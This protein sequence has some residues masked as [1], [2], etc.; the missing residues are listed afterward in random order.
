[1][2]KKLFFALIVLMALPLA[3][4]AGGQGGTPHR[5]RSPSA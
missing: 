2:K 4:F 1:M 3:V 5:A